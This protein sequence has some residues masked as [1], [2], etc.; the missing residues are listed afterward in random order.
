MLNP[1]LASRKGKDD[2][3]KFRDLYQDIY[4]ALLSEFVRSELGEELFVMTQ[5]VSK[6]EMFT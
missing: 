4:V 5:G 2:F 1:K 6:M 3:Y